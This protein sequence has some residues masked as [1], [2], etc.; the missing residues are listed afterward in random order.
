MSDAAERSTASSS[1]LLTLRSRVWSASSGT[2]VAALSSAARTGA[3][4]GPIVPTRVTGPPA[5][6]A[7]STVSPVR[8]PQPA[9]SVSRAS[10]RALGTWLG[11]P[12]NSC[13]RAPG[14]STTTASRVT[15][16]PVSHATA[17]PNRL[18]P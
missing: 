13:G 9:T 15:G 4:T 6:S 7:S 1:S 2:T 8:S 11:K 3:A 14:R 16:H 10:R 18:A 5:R 12:T 17:L